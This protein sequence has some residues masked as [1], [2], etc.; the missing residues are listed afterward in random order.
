MR[1]REF[2]A[3]DK[4]KSK[5]DK[6]SVSALPGAKKYPQMGI[7]YDLYRFGIAMASSPG[8]T[9]D[10]T[11]GPIGEM[12]MTVA[13]SKGDEEIINATLKQTGH[14]GIN[15][16]P[17]GSSEMDNVNKISPVLKKKTN[18]YGV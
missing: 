8:T 15:I 16:T 14:S 1:F 3:E 6:S 17:S 2:V 5:F 10:F 9:N 18:K 7:T 13:Y 4:N 12:P 11:E